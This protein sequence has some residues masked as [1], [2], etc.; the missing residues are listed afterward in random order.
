MVSGTTTTQI[1]SG[2]AVALMARSSVSSHEAPTPFSRLLF[3]G[4]TASTVKWVVRSCDRPRLG[5]ADRLVA[6]LWGTYRHWAG[7]NATRSSK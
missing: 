1:R 3:P 5:E 2:A 7:S 4:W 6:D